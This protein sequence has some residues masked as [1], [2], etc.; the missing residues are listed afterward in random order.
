M[1]KALVIIGLCATLSARATLLLQEGFNYPSGTLGANAPWVGATS[2]ITVSNTTLAFP[3]LTAFAPAS[4][5]ASVQQGSTAWSYRPLST[6][7][8]TGVVYLSFLIDFTTLPGSYYIAGL[9][10]STNAP[11][12]GAADDPL[13]F[14]DE[15][16]SSGF[17][18]GIRGKGGTTTYIS[19]SLI[20]LN[21]NTTYFVVLK[22]NFA[23]GQASLYLDPQPG[24]A[25]PSTPDAS[26]TG[27]TTVPNL[28]YFYLRSGSSTAGNFL[29]SMARVASTWSEA[30]TGTVTSNTVTAEGTALNAF[31]D[32]FQVTNFWI[33]GYSVNW[34]T[35][36]TNGNGP[37]M[38]IGT[39]SHCSAFA[40]AV[41]ELLGIYLLHPPQESDV[42]LANAQAVWFTTNTSGWFPIDSMVDAQHMVNAG[43]LVM[44]SYLSTTGSG[45]IC[46][47]RASPRTDASVYAYGPEEC[48]S[49][50][51]NYADTNA[52][53]GFNQHPGAFPVNI[54]YYGHTVTYPITPVWPA[55]S[56]PSL[57]NGVFRATMT[58]IVGRPYQIQWSSNLLNESPLTTFTN[59]NI[60]TSFF[61]N[62]VMAVSVSNTAQ[63]F[64]SIVPK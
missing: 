15:P 6:V 33:D 57:S 48:Q 13:D 42:D 10:Q 51:S 49:G 63:N 38:T 43:A 23:G 2:L 9:L 27:E 62:A 52:V 16:Y 17:R 14:I 34:L 25:E 1:L 4:L 41:A 46:V 35:G 20:P 56:Q 11:P 36:A 19:N 8:S 40:P 18:F 45:H 64:Y 26:S 22:Y 50:E 37:N 54:Y 21:T 47:L 59:S 61:T 58:T 60:P 55:F 24:A 5:C 30:T 53:T 29:V 32:S 7:A 28:E 44:A 39:A 31:L 12:G 3:N